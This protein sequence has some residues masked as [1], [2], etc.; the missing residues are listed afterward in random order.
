MAV[1]RLEGGRGVQRDFY[2][3]QVVQGVARDVL[4]LLERVRV[5][6]VQH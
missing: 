1:L 5:G 6:A 2:V 4:Q 3:G